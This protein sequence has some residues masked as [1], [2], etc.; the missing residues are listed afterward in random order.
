MYL[1]NLT[2]LGFKSFANKTA[3]NFQPG[4]TAI[5]G[6]NGCGKSN[7]SD[8]VRWVLGEQSAK[9]LRGEEMADVIF[10][11][12]DG[13]KPLGM[14]EVSLT[15]GGV[16]QDHLS[17]AG[18]EV[19]YHE[20]TITRRVFRDGGSEYYVNKIPCRLKDIQHLFMGTGLGRTS[21]SIMAQ[22]N[23]TQILSSKP[24]DRRMIFEE[25]AGITKYKAQRKE[26]LRKLEYTEQNLLRVADLVRE[27]KRQIG[28]LQ[29]QAAKARRYK[30]LAQELQHL[31]TQLARHHFDV[32]Q[33]EINERQAAAEGLRHD[34]EAA[35]ADLLRDEDE[36]AQRRSRLS[37]L[38][39]QIGLSQQH[40]LQL[41]SESDQRQSR[42]HFNQERLREFALQNAK[43]LADITQ[44]EERRRAAEA[45]LSAAT[46][47]LAASAAAR[48]A[49]RQALA[50]KQEALQGVEQDLRG[51]QETLRQTQAAAF[52]AAQ[53]LSRLR[54]EI[55]ALDLQK[56]G[57]VVR[58]DK[59]SAEKIQ[60][61][62]E[63]ARLETRLQE[64]AANVEASKRSVQTQRGTVEER[65]ERLG[66]IQ[67]ELDSAARQLDQV[68]QQQ[69]EKRSR[70][71]VLEQ[72]QAGHEG[73][74]AGSLAA[75]QQSQHVLG[76]LADKIHVPDQF[77]TA[78]ETALGHHLQLVLTEQAESAQQI[79]ADLAANQKGRASIA[80]LAFARNGQ[81]QAATT[82]NRGSEAGPGRQDAGAPAALSAIELDGVPLAA[83]E[84]VQSEASI[85]P[86]LQGLLGTTRIVRDLNAATVAWI[87]SRGAFHYVT[88]GG[89]VL[90][91]HGV[92][93][94]G[95]SGGNGDGHAPAS[96]L[97]RRNQIADLEAAV[98]R[99]QQQV[100]QI[101]RQRG[102]LQGEQSQLQAGLQQAQ[103]EL[104]AQEVAI[105]THQGEF[106]VLGN[107]H[108]LLHQK[109]DTVVYEIESLAAQERE[110]LEK[111]AGL[112]AKAGELEARE[113]AHQAQ[114]AEA[115]ARLETLRQQRD[116]ANAGLTESR[117]ALATAQQMCAAYE[118][119]QQSLDQRRQELSQFIEQ[120]RSELGD[121]DTRQEQAESEIQ[122]SRRQIQSLDQ[123]REQENA[124]TAELL[125]QK[126]AQEAAVAAREEALREQRRHLGEVQEQRSAL[127]I[128]LAQKTMAAQNLRQRVQE[129]Y[130]IRLDDVRSE[131]ITITFA[132]EG[133]PKIHVLTPD[134]MAAA[135]V[136]TSWTTV[137]QQVEA[138]QQRLDEMGPVNLVA[139][140]EYEETE[141][142]YQFLSQQHDD[143]LQAKAQLLEV[144]NRINAQTRQMFKQT[145]EQVR[146][147]FRALFTEVFDGGKAD[148]LLL[149]E[150]DLLESGI[151]I[152]A[153]PPGKQLQTI[154]LLSGGEQTMTAVA[155]L[156]SIYQVK[157]S[158]FCLLDEL[159]APLDEANIN[160]F[161]RILQRFLL[162]CQ[163]IIITHNKRTISMA[164]VLYG[165]TMREQGVSQLVSVKFHK[166]GERVTD[167]Q[168]VLLEGSAS[169]RPLPSAEAAARAEED[170]DVVMA[171]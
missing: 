15:I 55:N 104:R 133:P 63:R 54:N 113:Q 101:S 164:D 157:P 118:Q 163:F 170:T 132:D 40:G 9:A 31:D 39:H 85:R 43:A 149:D 152:V 139:I 48:E 12:T 70:L 52:A 37:E 98:V 5:V 51:C 162:H 6:P 95:S 1:K 74:S 68:L 171:K 65:Q 103:T 23:I 41:K 72:L 131:C 26:A 50:A 160:R 4:V 16:D 25:A 89:E 153:R 82:L 58:L 84:V 124:Q 79:L 21:Y 80:P 18:V 105:A 109:I 126:Q 29:R 129:K 100:A 116:A 106:N 150:N 119:Q 64:F 61:E 49:H 33:V 140:E 166:T 114:V 7:V 22:G 99:V 94:G 66:Q 59:L 134:E 28:S 30:Q 121:C 90:S 77:V 10:N 73:F 135:G 142:R 67:E 56:Q 112:G 14:A 111:R 62:E 96:I 46:E 87:A 155:L 78:I 122:D 45:E 130:H 151:D 69:A 75:L 107:S 156:F 93:T 13:R 161:L 53:D 154:S 144:I 11:G 17:A 102:G 19:A 81:A 24:E 159:D 3:L 146:E 92:Y 88:L 86:L 32:L 57:N 158:P 97:G 117:V 34:L 110:G 60:L 137:A 38:E 27:V 145:F 147:N 71:D 91:A 125:A 165:I 141:E 138:L 115:A 44:A 168:A 83:L 143:L 2:V 76:S 169:S 120:R 47:H 127:E 8:A 148:L 42:I 36:M 136:A 167:H 35:S 20:V 128:Q 108:R 123:E